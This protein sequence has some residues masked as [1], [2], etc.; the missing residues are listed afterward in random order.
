MIRFGI[1]GSNW[2]TERFIKAGRQH[3][4]FT[5]TAVY[6]RTEKKAKEF[7]WKH[8]IENAFNS[9]EE[10]AQS[11]E[12]DA[13]YIA[14]PNSLHCEQAVLFMNNSK[15][16]LCEKPFAANKLEAEIMITAA[17]DNGVTLMEA[18]KSTLMPNF[19]AVK[20]NL[21]K[22][23]KIQSYFSTNCRLSPFYEQYKQGELPNLFNPKFAGGSL[24]DLGVYTIAPIVDLFGVPKAVDASGNVLDSGVDGNGQITLHYSNFKAN[25]MFSCIS[26]STLPT[27]IQGEDGTILVHHISS[28]KKAEILFSSG[29]AEDIS[30]QE[31]FDPMYYEIE[32]FIDLIKSECLESPRNTWTNTMAVMEILDDARRQM[33][34]DTVTTD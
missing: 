27:E 14:T 19:L 20:E 25:V 8:Q 24:M 4:D 7:A 34:V 12:I 18:M 11:S 32:E 31:Q 10:M 3:A 2:I 16:V 26:E 17:K 9:L 21:H 29:V 30:E 23:G 33:G 15:H 22:I 28:P 5:V 1:V 13:V 6:S